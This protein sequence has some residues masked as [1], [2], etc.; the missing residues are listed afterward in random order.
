MGP[1]ERQP[2]R[3]IEPHLHLYITLSTQKKKL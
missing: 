3:G 1:P 2:P